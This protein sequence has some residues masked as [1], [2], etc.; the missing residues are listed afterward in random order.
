MITEA[1]DFIE[2]MRNYQFIRPVDV[3]LKRLCT[4]E[5]LMN[6]ILSSNT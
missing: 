5:R 3:N 4:N 1:N 2:R 6:V